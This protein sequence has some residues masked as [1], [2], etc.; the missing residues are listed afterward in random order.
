MF[1]TD[2]LWIEGLAK[3]IDTK[4][5]LIIF[6]AEIAASVVNTPLTSEVTVLSHYNNC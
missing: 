1:Q 6:F 4:I 2:I 3:V 5:K